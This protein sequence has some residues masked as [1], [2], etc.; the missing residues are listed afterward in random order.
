MT[1]HFENLKQKSK[2]K[3]TPGIIHGQESFKIKECWKFQDIRMLKVFKIK[4]CWKFS[5][6]AGVVR[7]KF[8]VKSGESKSIGGGRGAMTLKVNTKMRVVS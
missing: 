2:A 1:N 6:A 7:G 8:N 4:E 5:G 3:I